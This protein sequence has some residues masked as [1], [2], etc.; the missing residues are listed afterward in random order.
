MRNSTAYFAGV[1]T[2]FSATALG[3]GGAMVITNATAPRSP[4]EPSRLERHLAGP[5]QATSA[6]DTAATTTADNGPTQTPNPTPVQ[7]PPPQQ[8]Q[9]STSS[10]P[11]A[12]APPDVLGATSQPTQ[13]AAEPQT[14]RPQNAFARADNEEFRK[15]I[16]KRERRWARRHYQ[17]DN[18]PA[19]AAQ[20]TQS[21][22]RLAAS[23]D[24][25]PPAIQPS[26]QSPEQTRSQSTAQPKSDT[27]FTKPMMPIQQGPPASTTAAGRNAAIA[28]TTATRRRSRFATLPRRSRPARRSTRTRRRSSSC[29]AGDRCSGKKTTTRPELDLRRACARRTPNVS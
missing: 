27:A 15:I 21:S 19:I 28:T 18:A 4:P 25:A 23:S 17:D 20:D 16:R 3:F 2:V 9:Q 7:S 1:A 24:A 10:T 29:P 14:D 22:G 12:S 8:P 13:T 26:A 5:V 11:Q 6:Q